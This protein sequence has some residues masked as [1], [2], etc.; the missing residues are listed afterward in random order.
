MR[1]PFLL[2]LFTA[3]ATAQSEPTSPFAVPRGFEVSL[4]AGDELAHDIFSLTID[5]RGRVA[6]AGKGYVKILHDDDRDGR[7]DRAT[8]FSDRPKSGAHGLCFDGPHL[9]CTGDNS[10]MLLRDTDGDDKADG[11]PEIWASLRHPEHGANG[12]IKGP[13]GWFYLACG[14]DA[15]VSKKNAGT[16]ASPILEPSMGAMVRFSADGTTSE[17]YAHGFRNPYDL[18]FDRFGHLY[19]YDADGE[20]DHH[21]PWYTPTRVFDIQQGGH[22]GWVIKGWRRSWNR[23]AYFFDNVERLAELGR[24]SPTGVAS[25]RHHR[26]PQRYRRGVFVT[27]WTFGRVYFLPL[28][29]QTA[30]LRDEPEIFM[31]TTGS[32]GFAPVDLAVDPAGDLFVAIGGRGTRGSV[33]RVHYTGKLEEPPATTDSM[34]TLLD[35]PQPLSSH[36]RAI[37]RPL[38][39]K[40]GPKPIEEA[41]ADPACPMDRR[42]RAIELLVEHFGGLRAEAAARVLDRSTVCL[43]ARTAWALGRSPASPA[44][45]DLI[46]K[47]TRDPDPAVQRSAWEALAAQASLEAGTATPD[48]RSA[49]DASERRT[50]TAMI[51]AA[52]RHAPTTLDTID[53]EQLSP[54]ARL[55]LSWIDE[56]FAEKLD[57][58]LFALATAPAPDTQL[59]AVRLLQ[60]ALGDIRTSGGTTELD[61]GYSAHSLVAMSQATRQ[62]LV[63]GL[64][65]AFPSGNISLDRELARTLGILQADASLVGEAIAAQ[66]NQASHPHDDAHFLLCMAQL[67]G[68]RSPTVTRRTAAALANLHA[69]TETKGVLPGRNWSLHLDD[70]FGRLASLDPAL[71]AALIEDPS[72]GHSEH[73]FFALQMSKEMRAKAARRL[74]AGNWSVNTV[75]LAASLPTEEIIE[76]LRRHWS[77]PGLRDEI[78]PLL[79]T[80]SKVQDRPRLIEGLGSMNK[81]VV[82]KLAGALARMTK[83]PADSGTP[84]EIAAAIHALRSHE[85]TDG[86]RKALLVLLEQWTGETFENSRLWSAWM[87]AHHPRLAETLASLEPTDVQAWRTRLSA[88]DWTLGNARRG[89]IL[90]QKRAC[91]TCHVGARRLGPNLKG[92]TSRFSPEDLLLHTVFPNIAISPLYKAIQITTRSGEVHIGVPVYDSPAATILATGPGATVRVTG[93]Q[94]LR[95]EPATRSPMPA[96][97][98]IGTTDQNLADLWAHMNTLR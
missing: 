1:H 34:A 29:S 91:A 78:A 24:G 20:R 57:A 88:I 80:T 90:F 77:D 66:W 61:T 35:T 31:Q 65:T 18:A 8:L 45:H 10:V 69:K 42:I 71:P 22:H 95:I 68:N 48:W 19:T 5:A 41:A 89:E 72:F 6:V 52:R 60:V 49:L 32:V 84:T 74:I 79:A 11:E 86:P 39:L 97:L 58:G 36:S 14:N 67:P 9:V 37:T 73:G 47:L 51:A 59:E 83:P 75:R 27:C 87:T 76:E 16:A 13:D 3:T 54:R 38:A 40:L 44:T 46:A 62:R 2:L 12:I 55:T 43:R 7:A 23:P 92:I 30:A 82:R 94:T 21:L 98:L 33:Y 50:R 28:Q 56:P 93:E 15:G 26:F 70:C 85:G 63:E 4:Y 53:R 64:S 96:G 25:Y 17:V 81:T